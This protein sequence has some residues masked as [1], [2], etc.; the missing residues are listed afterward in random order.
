MVSG[1]C[2][3]KRINECNP[4]QSITMTMAALTW[5]NVYVHRSHLIYYLCAWNESSQSLRLY[6]EEMVIHRR[7][8]MPI[9]MMNFIGEKRQTFFSFPQFLFRFFRSMCCL[10]FYP[11]HFRLIQ[12]QDKSK[13]NG[14][15]AAHH[16]SIEKKSELNQKWGP[17]TRIPSKLK[18]NFSTNKE[19]KS[20]PNKR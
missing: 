4:I 2:C 20:K 16:C 8:A 9:M 6:E 10:E 18:L 5:L 1:K 19:K 3:L 14:N 17:S 7:T 11:L 15:K 13:I 12:C